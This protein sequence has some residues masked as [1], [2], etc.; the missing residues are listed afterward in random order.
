MKKTLKVYFLDWYDSIIPGSSNDNLFI[1][2]LSEYYDVVIDKNNPDV[3]FYA[4]NNNAHLSYKNCIKIFVTAEPGHWHP[5]ELYKYNN[6]RSFKSVNDAD[7]VLL[8]YKIDD[9]KY[10]YFPIFLLWLYH[11][12]NVTKYIKSYESLTEYKNFTI[13]DIKNR[14]FCSFL[15]ANPWPIKRKEIY[16]KLSKYKIIDSN[17]FNKNIDIKGYYNDEFGGSLTKIKFNKDYKF[18]FAF[19]NHF[20]KDHDTYKNPGFIDEKI[21]E[22]YLSNTIPLYYGDDNMYDFFN[23]GSLLNWHDFDNDSDFINKI[24]ELDNNDD[25]YLEYLNKPMLRCVDDLKLKELSLYLKKIIK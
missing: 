17:I 11:H 20:Y 6:D 3:L 15:Y 8:S 10:Y 19:S 24:I 5:N 14:K 25:L 16:D 2:L 22:S 18:T 7:H 12:I 21:L 1:Y 23:E 4:L 13:D 9:D